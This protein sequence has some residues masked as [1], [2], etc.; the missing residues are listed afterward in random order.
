MPIHE[1]R[2]S[3]GS[4]PTGCSITGGFVVRDPS[5]PE[6]AGRYVYAD[7]CTGWVR[8]LRAGDAGG[9]RRPRGRARLDPCSTAPSPSARTA[10]AGSTC[11]RRAAQVVPARQHGARPGDRLPGVPGAADDTAAARP[12]PS[13]GPDAHRRRARHGAAAARRRAAVGLRGPLPGERRRDLR[14]HR[15]RQRRHRPRARPAPEARP[16]HDARHLRAR[17]GAAWPPAARRRCGCASAPS[18]SASSAS[19]RGRSARR[20]GCGPR[21]WPPASARRPRRRSSCSARRVGEPGRTTLPGGRP[22]SSCVRRW[23]GA[24]HGDVTAAPAPARSRSWPW[25][26]PP[27]RRRPPSCCSRRARSRRPPS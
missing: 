18:R 5:V 11:C 26:R 16:P 4:G 3:G 21:S 17:H 24:A 9:D 19:A 22:M 20:C 25:R 27:G 10:C 6:L 13:P 8:S 15:L 1:Y 2:H 12:D 23:H 7:Y 14:R